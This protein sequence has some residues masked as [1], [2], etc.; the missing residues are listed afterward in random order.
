MHEGNASKFVANLRHS[1]HAPLAKAK[2]LD[3]EVILDMRQKE[4]RLGRQGPLKVGNSYKGTKPSK[5][6]VRSLISSASM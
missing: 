6:A 2:E 1:M 4:S 3:V 5:V